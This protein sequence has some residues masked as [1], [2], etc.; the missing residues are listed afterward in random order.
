M[1]PLTCAY[2]SAY[3]TRNRHALIRSLRNFQCTRARTPGQ[4]AQAKRHFCIY[5]KCARDRDDELYCGCGCCRHRSSCS[6]TT[7]HH[8]PHHTTRNPCRMVR[9]KIINLI[10]SI[11]SATCTSN[12]ARHTVCRFS[13]AHDCRAAHWSVYWSQV[14]ESRTRSHACATYAR[15]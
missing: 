13:V 10:L 6:A 1:R 3:C 15:R 2:A 5:Y 12:S 11:F 8:T 9:V 7:P 14:Q 4:A